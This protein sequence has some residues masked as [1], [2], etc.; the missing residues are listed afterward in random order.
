MNQAS[1]SPLQHSEHRHLLGISKSSRWP[2]SRAG[3]RESADNVL[4]ADTCAPRKAEYV[5]CHALSIPRFVA[6]LWKDRLSICPT[7]SV[8]CAI[9]GKS[10]SSEGE[11]GY[12]TP[13]AD[14]VRS[15]KTVRIA[16]CTQR[17]QDQSWEPTV[18]SKR[19][20]ATIRCIGLPGSATSRGKF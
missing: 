15:H 1:D 14:M 16:G 12:L 5:I 3:G 2:D 9:L 8:P 10:L 19:V 17:I 4:L 13:L 20:G 7:S 11:V 18:M 6:T